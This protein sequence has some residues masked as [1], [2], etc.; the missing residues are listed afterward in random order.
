MT[1]IK[2][3]FPQLTGSRR[4][5]RLFVALSALM[6]LVIFSFSLFSG[7]TSSRQSSWAQDLLA[8][9]TGLEW[10]VW[11]IRK[12]AHITEYALLGCFAALALAQTAWRP[13]HAFSLLGLGFVVGFLDESIQLLSRRGPAIAD[14]WLDG[15]GMLCGLGFTLAFVYLYRSLRQSL[16][17]S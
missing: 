6:V 16:G 8:L 12:L 11:I 13:R 3:M 10:D 9:L 4:L 2:G 14:V 5:L 17:Q 1:E 7:E 15:F